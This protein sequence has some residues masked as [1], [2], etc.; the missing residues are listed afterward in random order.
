MGAT[1]YELF[2]TSV[3]IKY[4]CTFP[5]KR[6]AALIGVPV[7]TVGSGRDS[8]GVRPRLLYI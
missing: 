6:S 8:S 5:N 4:G 2:S 3:H 1:G 7:T